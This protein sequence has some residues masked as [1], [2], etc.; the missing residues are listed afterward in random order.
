[1]FLCFTTVNNM[2]KQRSVAFLPS[3]WNNESRVRLAGPCAYRIR[4][5]VRAFFR[6]FSP[7]P[8]VFLPA[9]KTELLRWIWFRRVSWRHHLNLMP[10]P[11]WDLP[12]FPPNFIN[13]NDDDNNNNNTVADLHMKL[14]VLISVDFQCTGENRIKKTNKQTNKTKQT[15][16]KNNNN[17]CS[18]ITTCIEWLCKHNLDG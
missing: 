15:N 4:F 14:A 3:P 11:F 13:N 2:G 5:P 12:V 10:V 9:S 8:A 16:S 6:R 17:F 7:G 18:W 1:M